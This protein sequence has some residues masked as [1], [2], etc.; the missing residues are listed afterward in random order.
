[1]PMLASL[2]E[3]ML[4]RYMKIWCLVRYLIFLFMKMLDLYFESN[5]LTLHHIKHSTL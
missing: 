3:H 5:S 2:C 1:M 4:E